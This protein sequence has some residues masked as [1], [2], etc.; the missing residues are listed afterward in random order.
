MD[1]E[2]NSNEKSVKVAYQNKDISSKFL[3]SMHGDAFAK[4]LG[5]D[6][7]AVIR[8]EPTELPSIEVNTMMM[9]N[10]FLLEDGSYVIIDYESKYSEENKVKYLNYI[11]RLVKLLYNQ[12]KQIPVI[13]IIVIYTADITKDM[14]TPMV[15][16]G[17]ARVV[18]T[19]VFILDWNTEAI[20]QKISNYVRTNQPLS[21]EEQIQLIM[22]PLSVKG[23]AEKLQIFRKCTDIIED[24]LDDT[25][26]AHLYGGL[27]AFT[28]K[29]IEPKESEEIRRRLKMTK[30]EKIFY[31][32]KMEALN[33][34]TETIATNLLRD[35]LSPEMISRNTGLD[36]AVVEELSRNLNKEQSKEAMP[37]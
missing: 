11:A 2:E 32:E 14:T 26:R 8:N 20:L 17:G 15:D 3:A 4:A 23:K 13:H 31:D 22:L 12:D 36:L 10:L 1:N 28:D 18:L 19:E 33:R 16:I 30:I 35:G 9:D 21:E 37:V 29:I 5:I 7:P 24:I 25:M 6:M 27:V 34:K